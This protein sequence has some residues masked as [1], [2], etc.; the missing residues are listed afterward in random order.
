MGTQRTLDVRFPM[1]M[2]STNHT[3]TGDEAYWTDHPE[4][5]TR[6][7]VEEITNPPAEGTERWFHIEF[8]L[9][10][11]L[12]D[13]PFGFHPA[14]ASKPG[15][16]DSGFSDATNIGVR[17]ARQGVYAFWF[18]V[19]TNLDEQVYDFSLYDR[20][21]RDVPAE[22][23]I[24]ANIS[25]DISKSPHGYVLPGSYLPVDEAKYAAFVRATVERYD[26]DGV[27]DM[28]GLMNPIKYWQVD[29]E[30]NDV[31]CTNFADLQRIT[32]Q[33][34]KEA[35]A[36]CTVLI[37][38]ATSFPENYAS[39]FDTFYAPILSELAGQYV[40]IFDFHYYGTANGEY[41]MKDTATGQDVLDHI[42]ATLIAN[43]FASDLPIWITEM[44]SYSGDPV[45]A[46]LPPQSERQQALDYFK[47]FIYP[48]SRGVRKVF[49][50]FGLMEGF[51]HDDGYFD[52]TGLIYDGQ[53]SGDMGLGVKKLGYYTYKKMTEK[54]EGAD[55]STLTNL[56]DGTGSDHLYSFRVMK[57][58]E[59]MHIAWW[60]YFDEPGY[61]NGNTTFITLDGLT[62]A[63]V[64][65][66]SLVPAADEGQSVTNYATAFA[67]TNSAVLS[68]STTIVLGADPVI[69]EGDADGDRLSNLYE[70][71]IGADPQQFDTD[72]DGLSDGEEVTGIDN[73]L[74][75]P[76]PNGRT[77]NPL[78]A[79]T[80]GD[81]MCDG[82]EALAGTDGNDPNSL[83]WIMGLRP[84]AGNLEVMVSAVTGKTY[85]LWSLD[86]DLTAG[87]NWQLVELLGP[88][89]NTQTVFTDSGQND[90][91]PPSAAPFRFY[92]AEY[93]Y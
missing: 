21:W 6:T 80:D 53:D 33:A 41:R 66:T 52:H 70:Q 18:L 86:S 30:P 85:R 7:W 74:T 13:S 90:R 29:N 60:D 36:D 12:Q 4:C 57:Q 65:I 3:A 16:A 50:A 34:I 39:N 20:Q 47:R 26:G 28:P 24:L 76:D 91:P 8:D 54:L 46:W 88:A 43:D 67:L 87:T 73:A 5:V 15:Y 25:P 48:L 23:H 32:Y 14:N 72:G 59:E 45:G 62:G 81:G 40:D 51:K 38:G 56:H 42:R 27:D 69:I 63:A 49:P 2:D 89:T 64:V 31:T 79:D 82:N 83:F 1:V 55:W 61:T 68:G 71:E 11:M 19:Q 84:R 17:W 58:G 22:M 77:T 37:G 78:L 9:T 93:V 92:R 75:P 35:C 10:S 44:G